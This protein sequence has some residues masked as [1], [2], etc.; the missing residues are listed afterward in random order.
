MKLLKKIEGN[1]ILKDELK[2]LLI[3][4]SYQE[5]NKKIIEILQKE[6]DD[7]N[8]IIIELK[9]KEKI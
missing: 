5:I 2:K 4:E 6:G 1:N 3:K 8:K 7:I 9:E